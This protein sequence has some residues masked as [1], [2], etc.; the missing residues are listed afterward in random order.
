MGFAACF[1]LLM[2][3]LGQEWL[4]L[5]THSYWVCAAWTWQWMSENGIMLCTE[6]APNFACWWKRRSGS[7]RQTQNLDPGFSL[8]RYS[9]AYCFILIFSVGCQDVGSPPLSCCNS[10]FCLL[11]VAGVVERGSCP[12]IMSCGLLQTVQHCLTFCMGLH[13]AEM[14]WG[15]SSL[16]FWIQG[17]TVLEYVESNT[18]RYS[19]ASFVF[20]K[21][22]TFLNWDLRFIYLFKWICYTSHSLMH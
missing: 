22:T 1:V 8:R 3:L 6:N 2:S 11:A 16:V 14:C 17:R 12:V 5:L 9:L 20:H 15:V 18:R 13:S 4:L 21:G 10:G 7:A 19:D